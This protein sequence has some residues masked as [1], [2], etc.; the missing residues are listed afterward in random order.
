MKLVRTESYHHELEKR[1]RLIY[2]FVDQLFIL[3]RDRMTYRSKVGD[4]SVS[5][6]MI[7]RLAEHVAKISLINESS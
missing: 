2:D 5:F 1:I 4:Y 3:D 6:Y 7:D